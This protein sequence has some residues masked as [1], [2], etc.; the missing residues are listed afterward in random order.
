LPSIILGSV[1]PFVTW[2]RCAK[3]A[4]RIEVL[5][6]MKTLGDPRNIILYGSPD[7]LHRFDA[8][9]AKLLWLNRLCGT[10]ARGVD[11][12]T[13]ES[14]LPGAVGASGMAGRRGDTGYIGVIGVTGHTGSRGATGSVGAPGWTGATGL[15]GDSGSTGTGLLNVLYHGTIF[16]DCTWCIVIFIVSLLEFQFLYFYTRTSGSARPP[17]HYVDSP[18][19]VLRRP[20]AP[21]RFPY[22]CVCMMVHQRSVTFSG[23]G[24]LA[25]HDMHRW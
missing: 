18:V 12:S 9:F 5:L 17:G 7:F 19:P 16:S 24:L 1:S 6:G 22:P 25:I 10:G 21:P 23:W 8:A 3:V 2:P 11:G 13:G 20:K 14:G 4:E 15:H